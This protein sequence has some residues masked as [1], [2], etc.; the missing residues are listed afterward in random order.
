MANA[1]EAIECHLEGL[2]LDKEPIPIA[3]DIDNY[4]NKREYAGGIWALIEVDLSQISGRAKRINITLP[5]RILNPN[6]S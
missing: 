3:S 1:V 5:E 6:I 4:I 2:L